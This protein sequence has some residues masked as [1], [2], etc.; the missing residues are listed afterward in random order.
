M[1]NTSIYGWPELI[2]STVDGD[3][4]DVTGRYSNIADSE[5]DGRDHLIEEPREWTAVLRQAAPDPGA[6]HVPI[7]RP[8]QDGSVTPRVA[9]VASLNVV[10]EQW[11]VLEVQVHLLM[12][13]EETLVA[14][15]A[16]DDLGVGAD[17]RNVLDSAA[18]WEHFR[19]DW[20]ISGH[21]PEKNC[22]VWDLLQLLMPGHYAA[23]DSLASVGPHRCQLWIRLVMQTEWEDHVIV[24]DGHS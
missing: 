17:V 14:E 16:R 4:S 5:T 10:S 13:E 6:G 22:A 8:V 18:L 3:D 24:T 23:V 21:H 11:L 2:H 19:V 12:L 15:P 9:P 1:Y 20:H 7:L